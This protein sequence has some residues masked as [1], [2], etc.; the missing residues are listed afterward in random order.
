MSIISRVC[1]PCAVLLFA[2]LHAKELVHVSQLKEQEARISWQEVPGAV[3]YRVLIRNAHGR[4]VTNAVATTRS[5]SFSRLRPGSYQYQIIAYDVL[6]RASASAWTSLSIEK[7]HKP[8]TGGITPST[9]EHVVGGE[10]YTVVLDRSWM[11]EKGWTIALFPDDKADEAGA[12]VKPLSVSKNKEGNWMVAIPNAALKTG[13]YTL[14]AITPRNIYAEVRGILRVVLWRRPIFFYYDLSV[15]YAPVYRP[16]DHAATINGVSDFFKI[17]SPIGFVGTFEMCFFKRNSSTISAGFNAQ[18][19][20]DSK[21]VDV[22]LDGNFAYLYELYPRI[23][24]GGMLGL[25]Y[26]LP[27]GQ[28]KEDDSMYSYVT[29]T[30]KYFFTN[31]IYLRVQQ[32]HMLTVNKGFLKVS[33]QQTPS[34]WF[35]YRFHN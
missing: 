27:F 35:G 14:R 9:I 29:G 17:C 2:Q 28:R 15:G 23:E 12:Y 13:S 1:I 6:H 16:Q 3:S 8:K 18:M 4:I 26:S 24:V 19:H 7:V 30:M 5:Y 25:G 20:S 33:L 31:S 32:Q 22:K 21:Q 10:A 34:L 11:Y